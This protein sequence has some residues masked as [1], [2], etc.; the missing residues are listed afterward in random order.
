[1]KSPK[2]S[3]AVA[4]TAG[5]AAAT[6]LLVMLASSPGFFGGGGERPEVTH[7]TPMRSVTQP[8]Q[9]TQTAAQ[10]PA[11]ADERSTSRL[12]PVVEAA[13]MVTPSVVSVN[14][15]R[16]QRFAPR[17][18]LDQF[19]VPEGYEREV[20]GLGSGFVIGPE[21][22][23]LTNA[24]VVQ[25]ATEVVVT[26]AD[27]TDYP[28][29]LLGLDELSDLALLKVDEELPVPDF[30][31]SDALVIGEPAIAIGSPFGYLLS[32]VEPTV[33]AGVISG[34]GR[35]ILPSAFGQEATR[36]GGQTIYADMIQ[37]DASINPG[38]SGG[39][40]V[41]ADGQ[42]IGVNSTIFSRSGGSQGLGFAIPINRAL[43]ISEQLRTFKEVR[44]PW[45]GIEV[46]FAD[47]SRTGR[48]RGAVVTEVTPGSPADRA[49]VEEGMALLAVQGRSVKSPLD[50]EVELLTV[51][52]G[53]TVS[54]TVRDQ[55]GREREITVTVEDLPSVGAARVEALEG[56]ELV[57]LTPAI[58]SE[59][60]LRSSDGALIVDVSDEVAS[61][62]GLRSGDLIVRINRWP[63]A[64]ADEVAEILDYMS[65][66]GAIELYY[67][68]G[69]R[70][71]RTIFRI[72]EGG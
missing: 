27:G 62:T 43:R 29:K 69:G 63:V 28:A 21:G 18:L 45:V 35:H 58:Q 20:A 44:R 15:I 54:L 61:V 60:D 1:M 71:R 4:F 31:D 56:L 6:A 3:H 9:Q 17:S 70:Y 72:V 24:H 22:Y 59:R 52:P 68:R 11:V 8:R 46:N 13:N 12:T 7:A 30:G 65:G 38:N 33:T 66:R 55:S 16:R 41:N 53:E 36:S 34:V 32:N 47:D 23:I 67:E 39:A 42:V 19:F 49:R 57:S 2:R 10:R 64:D 48:R 25:G 50:W 14:V 5:A 26:T 37:T 51:L 40:L